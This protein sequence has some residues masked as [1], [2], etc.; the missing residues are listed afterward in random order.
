MSAEDV[1]LSE[2]KHDLFWEN[3]KTSNNHKL[4]LVQI[5]LNKPSPDHNTLFSCFQIV[6]VFHI[7]A[8]FSIH[9]NKPIKNLFDS[10]V[11]PISKNNIGYFIKII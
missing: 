7:L 8:K 10:N 1:E 4:T 3:W 5:A 11:S 6:R 2:L 9:I